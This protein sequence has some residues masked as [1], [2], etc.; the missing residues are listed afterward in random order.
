MDSIDSQIL[1]ALQEDGRK[2]NSD[3]AKETGLAP[4]TMLDRVKKLESKGI[5]KG[6]RAVVDPEKIGLKAQGFA[7]ISLDRHQVKNI[8]I[9]E[10]EIKKIS[11]VRAC[12]HITG[13]FD[14][15]LHVIAPD[16]G[17]FGK[18][19]KEKLATI[20]GMG[21]IETFIVYSELKPDQGWPIEAVLA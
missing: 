6:Y 1:K 18:L 20:P 9:L 2:K 14:Y 11:N 16:L 8:E 17:D 5:I 10:N 15:L 12:Y 3:L 4:S 7:C 19:I 13:R 21:K